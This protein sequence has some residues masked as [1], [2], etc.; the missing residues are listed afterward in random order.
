[1]SRVFRLL[2]VIGLLAAL[3]VFAQ[4]LPLLPESE[5]QPGRLVAAELLGR[6]SA[7]EVQARSAPAFSGY[8]LPV[9]ENAVDLWRLR[10]ATSGFDGGLTTV[11]AQLFVPVN[12]PRGAS[13]LFVY[14]SGTTG[15]A[16]RCA[17]SREYELPVPL[18][19]YRE[20]LASYAG[21]GFVTVLPDYLGF[22]EPGG[23]QAYFHALSETHVLLDAASAVRELFDLTERESELHDSLFFG[24]YSQGGHAAFAVA[25]NYRLYAP[26][27]PL[28]GV[29]SFA[30]TADVQ[31]LLSEA[32]YYAPYVVLS[33][34]AIYGAALIEPAL[35]L[36]SRWLPNLAAEG[37][38]ACVD[39]VQ[40]M[41]P[42][43]G[44]ALFTPEFNDALQ[45]GD[46]SEVA[47]GFAAAL[48]ENSTGLTGH[49][50]PALVIQGGRDVIVSDA[51]Q[52][53]FVER[54]CALGSAVRYVN[55]PLARHRDTR[56]AGFEDS[57]AW[58]LQLRQS[59]ASPPSDCV[60]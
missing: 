27:V 51:V 15:I 52:E 23:P 57:I 4:P 10:V 28:R 35:I 43:D 7:E 50:V 41:Y 39:R 34:R 56:P 60:N 59:E 38:L 36:A 3:P 32:A 33:Y 58:M 16:A 22:D 44:A 42:Y 25:D 29:L 37:A 40:V 18:G 46:V 54:L 47:P 14:G 20:L 30:G 49:G 12:P 8:G 24:G 53:R 31:A 9:I 45:Q 17:P 13:S 19:Y 11:T 1:M 21:R 55:Y 6:W 2:V 5:W 48:A 26:E